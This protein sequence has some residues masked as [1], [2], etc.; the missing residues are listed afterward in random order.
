[1]AQT[2]FF[3]IWKGNTALK[4]YEILNRSTYSRLSVFRWSFRLDQWSTF[5]PRSQFKPLTDSI[6]RNVVYLLTTR[7]KYAALDLKGYS[8]F[9]NRNR[10]WHDSG[11]IQSP[12]CLLHGYLSLL[13]DSNKTFFMLQIYHNLH[14]K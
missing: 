14:C 7:H 12:I 3:H 11:Q 1:M 10:D 5:C 4:F 6:C 2:A 9:M 13:T 8:S